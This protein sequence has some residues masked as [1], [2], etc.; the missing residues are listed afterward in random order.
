MFDRK[1]L[2]RLI[3]IALPVVLTA[4]VATLAFRSVGTKASATPAGYA[5]PVT[6]DSH[7]TITANTRAV[8]SAH[9]MLDLRPMGVTGRTTWVVFAI[10]GRKKM[11][12]TVT[13]APF[14]LRIDTR[15]LPNGTYTVSLIVFAKNRA[16]VFHV[17]RLVVNNVMI[18][19]R[20]MPTTVKPTA[21]VMPLV[22]TSTSPAPMTQPTMKPAAPSQ[23]SQLPT[24]TSTVKQKF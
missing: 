2:K 19:P 23:L 6:I 4:L 8:G 12:H 21:P 15:T 11:V 24:V 9:G 1:P 10:D 20:A 18:R 17:V 22:A 13:R 14:V 5:R 16:P 7:I 3:L